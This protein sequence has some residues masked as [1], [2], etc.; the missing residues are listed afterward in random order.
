[1]GASELLPRPH[2]YICGRCSAI[3]RS[4]AQGTTKQDS[5]GQ[6]QEKVLNSLRDCLLKRPILK[7]QSHSK[8]F[9]LRTDASNCGLGATLMQEHDEKLY[10]VAYAS[11]KLASAKT[12]YSTFEKECLGIVWAITKFG[13]YSAGKPLF[14]TNRSSAPCIY[15]QNQVPE[16]SHNAICP[17]FTRV[18]LYCTRHSSKG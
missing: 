3:D 6:A 4:N 16:R 12:N 18:R 7:L 8:P 17:G 1:M 5:M 14:F 15:K 9:I 11:K 13:L 10:P 2:S